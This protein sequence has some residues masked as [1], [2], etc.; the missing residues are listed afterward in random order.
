MQLLVNNSLKRH[1]SF[2]LD[3][4]LKSHGSFSSDVSTEDVFDQ[5]MDTSISDLGNM[6]R[7]SSFHSLKDF[8]KHVPN[9]GDVL[10]EHHESGRGRGLTIQAGLYSGLLGHGVDAA[11]K[12]QRKHLTSI[13]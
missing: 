1:G 6:E 13:W 11:L 9:I 3:N 12:V 7:I 5:G 8:E 10:Q 2:S 4:S